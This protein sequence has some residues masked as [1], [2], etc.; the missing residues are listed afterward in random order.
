MK[1]YWRSLVLLEWPTSL[2]MPV[3]LLHR[4][5]NHSHT[6]PKHVR[7]LFFPAVLCLPHLLPHILQTKAFNPQPFVSDFFYRSV[8]HLY[9]FPR[10]WQATRYNKWPPVQEV[11]R[12]RLTQRWWLY[13]LYSFFALY[14]F[15]TLNMYLAL[16]KNW[17][18]WKWMVIGR[19]NG[20]LWKKK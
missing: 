14:P 16:S 20:Y 15:Q 17:K 3:Y 4:F 7:I 18:F 8:L 10:K 9:F 11:L 19:K 13:F 5:L 12:N 2:F 1:S 6:S